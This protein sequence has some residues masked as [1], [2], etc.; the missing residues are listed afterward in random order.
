MVTP[1]QCLAHVVTDDDIVGRAEREV[2]DPTLLAAF[3]V[4]TDRVA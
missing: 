2:I 3:N 1:E 4:P